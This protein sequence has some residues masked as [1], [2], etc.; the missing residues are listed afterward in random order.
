MIDRNLKASRLDQEKGTHLVQSAIPVKNTFSV[1]GW[2]TT[3][4]YVIIYNTTAS[5]CFYS[6]IGPTY[7]DNCC[8]LYKHQNIFNFTVGKFYKHP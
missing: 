4:Q 3:S 7:C 8:W 1:R 6:R 2:S 5:V